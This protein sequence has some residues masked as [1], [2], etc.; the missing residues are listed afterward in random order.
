MV[1]LGLLVL[2]PLEGEPQ[3]EC[4]LWAAVAAAA[5]AAGCW[6]KL[7]EQLPWRTIIRRK[8]C[9]FF[10]RED[11]VGVVARWG[12]VGEEEVEPH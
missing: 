4:E 7:P 12:R 1:G 8:Q 9:C 2:L 11:M 3:A 6:A 5:A 10:M